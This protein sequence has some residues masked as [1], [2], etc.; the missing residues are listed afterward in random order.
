M[1][2][3]PRELA[4]CLGVGI[5]F[6]TSFLSLFLL[7]LHLL[8]FIT[9]FLSLSHIEPEPFDVLPDNL[10]AAILGNPE[11]TLGNYSGVPAGRQDQ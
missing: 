5:P 6:I 11:F 8:P 9:S 10:L 4:S 3:H 7:L 1:G 2:A